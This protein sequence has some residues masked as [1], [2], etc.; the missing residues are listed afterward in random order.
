MGEYGA[1]WKAKSEMLKN[2]NYNLQISLAVSKAE[3]DGLIKKMKELKSNH[4]LGLARKDE[5]LKVLK[6]QS[7][8]HLDTI[9]PCSGSASRIKSNKRR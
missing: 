7:K 1:Y 3:N 9:A 2:E 6:D 4:K 8:S 5:L